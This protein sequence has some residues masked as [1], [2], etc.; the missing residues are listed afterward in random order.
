MQLV[1]KMNCFKQKTV[2]LMANSDSTWGLL[3]VVC[4]RFWKKKTTFKKFKR[5][6]VK[7]ELASHFIRKSRIA[8]E[9]KEPTH[10]SF[11]VPPC[12]DLGGTWSNPGFL[13]NGD[14]RFTF[15]S[16]SQKQNWQLHSYSSLCPRPRRKW[17]GSRFLWWTWSCLLHPLFC[18]GPDQVVRLSGGGESQPGG[19][20]LPRTK[21]WPFSLS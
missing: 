7:E 5:L 15:C 19:S 10:C 8:S 14:M 4:A 9:C 16:W 12:T 3:T 13:R 2:Y 21:C 18:F 11:S 17:S 6:R 20:D 1:I